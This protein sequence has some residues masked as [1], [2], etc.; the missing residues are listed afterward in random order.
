MIA[1]YAK[2][3]GALILKKVLYLVMQKPKADKIL[4]EMQR[5]IHKIEKYY[6]Y[7]YCNV[8]NRKKYCVI[9][10]TRPDFETF[11]A[12]IQYMF[13]YHSLVKQGYV[14]VI[15]MEYAYS[16]KQGRIGEFNIWDICFEQNVT[17]EEV[18]N[19]DFVIVTGDMFPETFDKRLC[20]EINKNK[21][22]HWV[23]VSRDN[24]KE[25]YKIVKQYVDPIWKVKKEIIN[26]LKEEIGYRTKGKRGIGVFFREEFSKELVYTGP[27]DE[28]VLDHHP[29]L[30]SVKE[31]VDMLV[32]KTR[33]WKY[34]YIF[35]S[36][37]FIETIE[38]VENC[39]PGKVVY[40]ARERR[41]IKEKVNDWDIDEKDIYNRA[42][43]NKEQEIA[44][45]QAY[46]KEVIAL[47]ECSYLVGGP[48]SGMAAALIMNGG[49]YM[50]ICVLDDERKI[51]RY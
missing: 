17:A 35:I 26:E 40:I 23:H 32:T 48:S 14:P 2:L 8:E 11:A 31:I 47:S 22:D 43:E 4:I 6:P 27:K 44:K 28:A 37:Q 10:F 9:R 21:F 50:D 3:A 33:Q 42:I 16:Y 45:A 39:F 34:D 15:D 24:Y 29:L 38:Y 13:Y 19:K 25:Y 1:K 51:A 46:V 12:G 18:N 7:A 30:P 41:S 49:N 20:K 5:S 36:S